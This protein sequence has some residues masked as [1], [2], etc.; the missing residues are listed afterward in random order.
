MWD[1]EVKSTL[2]DIEDYTMASVAPFMAYNFSTAVKCGYKEFEGPDCITTY[3][4]FVHEDRV[5]FY[6]VDTPKKQYLVPMLSED[7]GKEGALC[8]L[9]EPCLFA[10]KGVLSQSEFQ[11]IIHADSDYEID[12]ALEAVVPS[13]EETDKDF[14]LRNAMWLLNPVIH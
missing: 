8:S 3:L 10:K 14:F 4:V 9:F 5:L 12:Q 13:E 11:D 6:G 1:G 2:S 7:E